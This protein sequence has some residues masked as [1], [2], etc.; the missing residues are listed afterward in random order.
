MVNSCHYAKIQVSIY[1]RTNVMKKLVLIDILI[2]LIILNAVLLTNQN[3]NVIKLLIDDLNFVR[4]LNILIYYQ[5]IILKL[6]I[7][8]MI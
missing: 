8:W 7:I 2:G 3:I 1:K 6:L 5:L 4:D